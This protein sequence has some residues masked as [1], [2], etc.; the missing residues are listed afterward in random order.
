M[1]CPYRY[2]QMLND[3]RERQDKLQNGFGNADDDDGMDAFGGG[4][5]PPAEQSFGFK[6]TVCSHRANAPC[7]DTCKV[8]HSYHT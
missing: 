1:S 3:E 8:L 4:N 5:S 7:M 2:Q 6:C